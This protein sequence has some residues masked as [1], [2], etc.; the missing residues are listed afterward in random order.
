MDL[1]N[2]DLEAY[3]QFSPDKP[4]APIAPMAPLSPLSPEAEVLPATSTSM[5]DGL[6]QGDPYLDYDLYDLYDYSG[7]SA[8]DIS[9]L[10]WLHYDPIE[11]AG[12]NH[13]SITDIDAFIQENLDGSTPD[14]LAEQYTDFEYEPL[15]QLTDEV[16]GH[17][18]LSLPP[19]SP[20]TQEDL[21]EIKEESF[22]EDSAT[23]MDLRR[24]VLVSYITFIETS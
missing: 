8:L 1:S 11:S 16:K 22:P 7:R 24:Y 21:L 18:P 20:Q 19:Y 13:P 4:T 3:I 15:D 12:L 10:D 5:E 14:G 2:I 17:T 6:N 9:E 23:V